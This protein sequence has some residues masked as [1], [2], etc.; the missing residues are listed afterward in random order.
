[1]EPENMNICRVFSTRE[2]RLIGSLSDYLID[3][4][5]FDEIKAMEDPVDRLV[6]MMH[7]IQLWMGMHATTI[8]PADPREEEEAANDLSPRM[9]DES[10]Q[11]KHLAV[12]GRI[13]I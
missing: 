13:V 5:D 8:T 7:W 3:N 2:N 10:F 9:E 11:F 1:M 6:L 12:G 4:V